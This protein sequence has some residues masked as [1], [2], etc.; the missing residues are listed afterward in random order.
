MRRQAIFGSLLL[1]GLC[2]P[3]FAAAPRIHALSLETQRLPTLYASHSEAPLWEQAGVPSAAA[4]EL[5]GVLQNAEDYG[6]QPE[7]YRVDI[8]IHGPQSRQSWGEWDREFSASLLAFVDDLHSGRIDP[9]AAGFELAPASDSFKDFA[10]LERLARGEDVRAVLTSV[11]P[12]FV[13]YRLLEEALPRYQALARQPGLT[14]LPALPAVAIAPDSRYVGAPALRQLLRALGCLPASASNTSESQLVDAELVE[15][16]KRFQW[17]HGLQ[18]DGKLGP[19]TY[20][21]LTVPLAQRLRQMEL[22]LER[23]RWLPP[24]YYPTILVN[25]PEFRLFAF[26]SDSDSEQGMLRMDV[27]VGQQYPRTRTPVFMADL[28]TVVFRPYWDVPRSIVV[29]EILPAIAKDP[30]YLTRQHMEL[31]DGP[32]D[33]SPVVPPTAENIRALEGG[34]LRLRQQPGADNAL[35]LIKFL[36]P[37]AHDV[38]LHST[39]AI[40]LFGQARRT[41]SHGCIRVSDPVALAQY[42]LSGTPG[43]WTRESILAAM[44]NSSTQRVGLAHPIHVLILYGTAIASEDGQLHFFDDIYGQ[45]ERLQALLGLPAPEAY[46]ARIHVH[47]IGSRVITYSATRQGTGQ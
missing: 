8:L 33:G 26:A 34:R 20:A 43:H 10:V 31:V 28:R 7:D 18:I 15:G 23:W 40:Q 21:A 35:G 19:Q 1:A 42:V 27:I 16:L 12:T 25:I 41:F 24:L 39:P 36:L 14:H 11:E 4:R 32:A 5:L 46:A 22:T 38:Y 45:D 37:N 2:A 30:D 9:R 47:E 3:A 13:H 17:L 44:N 6:L 29:R